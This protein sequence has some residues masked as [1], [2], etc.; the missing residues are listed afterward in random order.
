MPSGPGLGPAGIARPGSCRTVTARPSLTTATAPL[1]S[2]RP[3]NKVRAERRP[4]PQHGRTLSTLVSL[5]FP[6]QEHGS[7]QAESQTCKAVVEAL[8]A[9]EREAQGGQQPQLCPAPCPRTTPPP[10]LTSPSPPTRYPAG[11]CSRDGGTPGDDRATA[12]PHSQRTAQTSRLGRDSP[13]LIHQ[14]GKMLNQRDQ[15]PPPPQRARSR[16]RQGT[17]PREPQDSPGH[18]PPAAPPSLPA[19]HHA[20]T[21]RPQQGP[22]RLQQQ[23]RQ[24]PPAPR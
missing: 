2:Y 8:I 23:P 6:P 4:S 13:T 5:A 14:A 16:Q 19:A 18:P 7:I 1:C 17:T 15:V 24:V 22:L 20:P 21:Q 3:K 11:P 9:G 12:S 10:H